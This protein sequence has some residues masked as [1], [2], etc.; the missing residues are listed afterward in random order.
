MSDALYPRLSIRVT[1]DLERRLEAVAM[2][3]DISKS[4]VVRQALSFYFQSSVAKNTTCEK[5]NIS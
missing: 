5:L 4:K 2:S 1:P 3:R